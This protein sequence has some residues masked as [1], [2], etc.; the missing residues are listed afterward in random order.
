MKAAR[1]ERSGAARAAPRRI[2]IKIPAQIVPAPPASDLQRV[3]LVELLGAVHPL[4]HPQG[5]LPARRLGG[6]VG[7]GE[8]R[9]AGLQAARAGARLLRAYATG[10]RAYTHNARAYTHTYTRRTNT[11]NPNARGA[12]QVRP[13]GDCVVHLRKQRLRRVPLPVL[14]EAEREARLGLLAALAPGAVERVVLVQLGG[15]GE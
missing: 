15:G 14:R 2:E 5:A 4:L 13:R 8:A 12:H 6:Q 1:A 3:P 9:R 11:H 7:G 10:E